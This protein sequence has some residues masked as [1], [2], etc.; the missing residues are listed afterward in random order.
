MQYASEDEIQKVFQEH[1][2]TGAWIGTV[3]FVMDPN[4][5][6]MVQFDDAE[7]FAPLMFSW[8]KEK[9][10]FCCAW[11]QAYNMTSQLL[12]VG[13]RVIALGVCVDTQVL[14]EWNIVAFVDPV[15][16]EL[17]K[18][19]A[20]N[21]E[22]PNGFYEKRFGEEVTI[23]GAYEAASIKLWRMGDDENPWLARNMLDEYDENRVNVF[24]DK[25][26]IVFHISRW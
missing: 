13:D 6:T 10:G 4:N 16:I 21:A 26:G 1:E 20:R 9:G 18:S 24:V 15:H 8:P 23:Q 22:D 12:A 19:L 5:G 7:V 11:V 17:V 14:E 25:E 3:R 2:I